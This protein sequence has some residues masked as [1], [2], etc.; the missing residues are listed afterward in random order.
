MMQFLH[1]ARHRQ[2]L[3]E[4]RDTFRVWHRLQLVE[5]GNTVC[6]HTRVEVNTASR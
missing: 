5:I 4:G 6:M 3:S 1:R 2:D